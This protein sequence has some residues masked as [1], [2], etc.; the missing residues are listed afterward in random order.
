M[1]AFLLPFSLSSFPAAFAKVDELASVNG[2]FL[3]ISH[4]A[5]PRLVKENHR[6]MALLCTF[7]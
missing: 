6:V 2:I 3:N 7:I 1:Y 5:A 4:V